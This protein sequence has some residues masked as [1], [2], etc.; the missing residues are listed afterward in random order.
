MR[1]RIIEFGKPSVEVGL[2]RLDRSVELLSEGDPIE[3]IEGRLVETLDDAVGLRALVLV[4]EW[5]MS[6]TAR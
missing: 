3:L 4:R 1:S 6:S 5:S 2:Q